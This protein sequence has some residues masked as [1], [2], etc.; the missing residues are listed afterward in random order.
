MTRETQINKM[1]LAL[2]LILYLSVG[3]TGQEPKPLPDFSLPRLNGRMVRSQEL[4][5]NIVV[6]D[7]WAT[8]CAPCIA[9]VPIFNSLQ[10][11]YYSRGVRVIGLASQSGWA[12]EVKRFVARHK[13]KYTVLVGD[14]ETVAN[15]GVINFPT[16]YLIAPGWKVYKKY[17]GADEINALQIE[18]DIETLLRTKEETRK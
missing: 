3:T 16:T 11:K 4:K 8:W 12:R 5:D 1:A 15:F 2:A 6:L 7:F 10:R 18:R 17:S 14:D 13:M 9:E